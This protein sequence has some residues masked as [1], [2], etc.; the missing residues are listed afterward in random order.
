MVGLARHNPVLPPDSLRRLLAVLAPDSICTY[1]RCGLVAGKRC[2][3]LVHDPVFLEFCLRGCE[4]EN[5][6]INARSDEMTTQRI[7]P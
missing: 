3:S 7:P 6:P 5:L 1:P 2:L 4:T